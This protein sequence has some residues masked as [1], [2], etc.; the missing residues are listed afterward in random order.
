MR[1]IGIAA[2]AAGPSVTR[3]IG[4]MTMLEGQQD[5][6]EVVPDRVLRYWAIVFEGL[7][8]D[9]GEVATAA[10]FH[11]YI[12]Y[13]SIPVDITVVISYNVIVMEVFQDVPMVLSAV[14]SR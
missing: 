14:G 8:D 6:H 9:I 11:E 4:M 7:L 1:V 10:V 5:L 2:R 12:E 3:T 13:A